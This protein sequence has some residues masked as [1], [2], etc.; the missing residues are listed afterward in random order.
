MDLPDLEHM[1]ETFVRIEAP[2]AAWDD[3]VR[4]GLGR[5]RSLYKA[6]REERE[7]LGRPCPVREVSFPE[8][9][10]LQGYYANLRTRITPLVRELMASGLINWFSFQVHGYESGVPTTKEDRASYVHLR[11]ALAE[12]ADAA[13]LPGRLPTYCQMT[14]RVPLEGALAIAGSGSG[15]DHAELARRIWRSAGETADTLL[16][17]LD[18]Y[19]SG[20][21]VPLDCLVEQ[22]HL[23]ANQLQIWYLGIDTP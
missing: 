21:P 13:T 19:P 2:P 3:E 6:E 18:I 10:F 17:M 23:F 7:R 15:P 5:L 4:R 9:W 22:F 14:Q 16:I 8:L 1:I 12:G 11:M 20:K